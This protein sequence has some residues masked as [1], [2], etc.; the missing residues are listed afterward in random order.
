MKILSIPSALVNT[1]FNR[2]IL[3]KQLYTKFYRY[4]E[5]I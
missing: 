4:N 3:S 5:L 2:S 1:G